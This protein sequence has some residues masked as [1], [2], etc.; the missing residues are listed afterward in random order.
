MHYLSDAFSS[1]LANMKLNSA[2]CNLL[3]VFGIALAA[4]EQQ[5]K[6]QHTRMNF[7]F[8]LCRSLLIMFYAF[9]RCSFAQSSGTSR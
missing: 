8:L 3:M 7:K 2:K 9:N 1:K 5:Q 4:G 6:S